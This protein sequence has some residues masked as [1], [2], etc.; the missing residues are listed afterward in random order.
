[1]WNNIL[2]VFLLAQTAKEKEITY[3]GLLFLGFFFFVLL[4]DTFGKGK[5]IHTKGPLKKVLWF[6]LA[7]IV[8]L[9]FALQFIYK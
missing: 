7:L 9:L 8:I 1:M 6:F 5:F 2:K 3:Y 4:L